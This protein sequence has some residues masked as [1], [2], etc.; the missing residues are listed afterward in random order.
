MTSAVQQTHTQ[1]RCFASLLVRPASAGPGENDLE[2]D[3]LRGALC[4]IA[5]VSVSGLCEGRLVVLSETAAD[6]AAFEARFR[7]IQALP[8]AADVVLVCAVTDLE[9]G[10]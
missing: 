10:T 4:E 6:T 9:D 5:G 3:E 1:G 2:I 8:G 7:Q